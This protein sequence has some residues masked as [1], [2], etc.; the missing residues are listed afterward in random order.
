MLPDGASPSDTAS[1]PEREPDQLVRLIDA[2]L[3][4]RSSRAKALLFIDQFEELVTTVSD[5]DLQRRFVHMLVSAAESPRIRL[6][7]TVRSDFWHRCIEAQPSIADLLRERGVT[8]PLAVPGHS[9]LA[10]MIDGPARRAG[11]KFD[12]GLVD[13]LVEATMSRP[14]G[15]A[16]LA[17]A[18][19]ELY[20]TRGTDGLLS[21][22]A[23]ERLADW[24]E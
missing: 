4:G 7:S 17:F 14:G 20:E 8:V 18:L 15:L 24:R 3:A 19:H 9:A 10:D 11:L 5:A 16:L 22:A 1:T 2:V 6:V 23:Y 13:D 12:D 21:R